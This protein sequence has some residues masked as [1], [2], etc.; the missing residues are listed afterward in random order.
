MFLDLTDPFNYFLKKY[1]KY[2]IWFFVFSF[3]VFSFTKPP[4]LFSDI[5]LILAVVIFII[6]STKSNLL[7]FCFFI[8]WEYVSV[9]SFGITLNSIIPGI[10]FLK[11]FKYFI[12]N[13]RNLQKCGRLLFIT[14]FILFIYLMLYGV[15]SALSFKSMTAL[16]IAFKAGFALYALQFYIDKEESYHFWKSVLF[17]FTISSLIATVFGILNE[18]TVQRYVSGAEEQVSQLYGTLGTTRIGMF[19]IV[20]LCYP[21]YF[22]ENKFI[23][24]STIIILILLIFK[25]V[26]ITCFILLVI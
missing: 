21:F 18:T 7:M 25:T 13:F 8:I 2:S 15:F 22:T 23:K 17:L 19:Y 4:S 3:F 9:F 14:T 12:L 16:G 6:S 5:I 26:S 24:L 10:L 11:I 1:E 20:A